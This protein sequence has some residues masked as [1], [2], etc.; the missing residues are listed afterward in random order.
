M[1]GLPTEKLRQRC[2]PA[3]LP[4]VSTK[5]L[6]E[7]TELIG[8]DRAMD[9]IRLSSQISHRDFNLFVLG[10]T[11]TGRRTAVL[12]LLSEQAATRELPSDWVYVNNFEAAHKPEAMR[13]P[14]GTA[15]TLKR[16]M[17]NLIDDLANDIPALFES[18]EYQTQRRAIEQ[19]LGEAQ[20]AAMADFSDRAKAEEIALV[21]T[22][23]G[24]ML[25]A[26]RDGKLVKS[27][28]FQKLDEAE[29][30]QISEK[31]SRLQED[32]A[33]VLRQTPKLE[34]EHRKRVEGLNAGMAERAVSARVADIEAEL[35]KIEV[36]A[37]YLAAVR[38]DIIAN[39]E[40]FLQAAAENHDGP[41]PEAIRKY[42]HKP[43]FDRY[44]VNVMVSQ[45]SE[46][47]IGAPVETEDLPTLD[48]VAGRIEHVSHMGSLM[49]NFTMIKPGALHRANGGYLVLDA[50]Q[51]LSEPYAWD[52]LKRCL[53]NQSIT[54]TSM[55]DRLSLI[56][57]TSLEPDPIPLDVRVVLVGDRMLHSLLVLLDPDFNELFKLQADFEDVVDRTQDNLILFA[58]LVGSYVRREG[59]RPISAAGVARA[60]D[61]ATRL[62]DDNTK[63]SLRLGALTDLIREADH[64]AASRDSDHI[65]DADIERAVCEKDRR[66]SRIKDRMQE[67]ITRKT[68]LIDTDGEKIGQINGLSVVGMGEYRFGR[69]SRITA[70]VR[71]GTG[72][73]VDIERE[74]EL[75]GP[76]HSKGVMILSGY[77][78]SAY[79][80]DVPF[81]LHASLVFEQSYGGVDG[82]S[83]SSAELYALLSALSGLPIRQG[84]AVTGSVNQTG[85]VQA[86][87]GVNE[88][89]EGFFE[90]CAARGL[91]GDQG[92][93]IPQSNIPHLM[94]RADVVEAAEA[95]KFR[96]IP[97]ATIDE[98]IAILTG[99]EAGV[100]DKGGAFPEASV[101][102][103]VE[104]R[105]RGFALT[106]KAFARFAKSDENG[107]DA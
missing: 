106:R 42:H 71:M 15:L 61:E 38:E 41:F 52:T 21:Q 18:E 107:N 47:G 93:L 80:L 10:P 45:D 65:D 1:N 84:L 19:E 92:V 40:L 56:S 30:A 5:D 89:I 74:V 33:T 53:K 77:L 85:E 95:G 29:Q 59:L 35:Q 98:G 91:T 50:R 97:V 55:A 6:V 94:L 66:A 63:L 76:L 102:A 58:R 78:T 105:L 43:E 67:A 62:A 2:D 79:A 32:L 23:M 37:Q 7:Q 17:Q 73:L 87:G 100:R 20:E 103:L 70:R 82:D 72:K 83:A 54:I 22:P 14:P 48:R 104:E 12:K 88:K 51:V 34:K 90:T 4:F 69:P 86:I 16:T 26:V 11:G 49:T 44:V 99:V 25:T 24:F 13:L 75:G 3:A 101:N 46:T 39:A 27:E 81:S 8:Q 68:I 31:I 36:V 96:V 9:A 57:T 28:D 60:L 64:Y